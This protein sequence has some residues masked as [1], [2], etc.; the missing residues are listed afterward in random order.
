MRVA[1]ERRSVVVGTAAGL[2]VA[3]LAA[4]QFIRPLG[5]QPVTPQEA[6][7]GR[8]NLGAMRREGFAVAPV[9]MTNFRSEWVVEGVIALDDELTT[10][11]FSPYSGRVVGLAAAVG[12]MVE[13]GAPLFSLEASEIAQAQNELIAALATP[14]PSESSLVTI[15]NRLR[16]LGESDGEIA[17]LQTAQPEKLDPIAIIVAPI[18]GIVT[19]Q[20]IGTGEF[21]DSASNGAADPVYEIVD[22]STVWLEAEIP[23]TAAP[24]MHAG[25][26][27]QV[28]ARSYPDRMFA[29]KI[30]WIAPVADSTTHRLAVRVD[31]ENSDGALKPAMPV[32]FSAAA[33]DMSAATVPASD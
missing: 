7:A 29:G 8:V 28:R 4:P 27:V 21:V 19:Q 14:H 30:S 15:R 23:E 32:S 12:D 25:A 17:A 31:I 20:R 6:S 26:A 2:L 5:S 13:R 16:A 24:S 1:M 22:F 9:V 11:V 33:R 18:A 10:P 3:V